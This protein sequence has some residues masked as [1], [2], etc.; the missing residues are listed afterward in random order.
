MYGSWLNRVHV[1]RS[2][3]VF[4]LQA[5]RITDVMLSYGLTDCERLHRAFS[6]SG[7]VSRRRRL[8]AC[9]L[10]VWTTAVAWRS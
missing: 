7:T 8:E 3:V 4:R 5:K 10:P 9:Y 2:T 1:L 6:V